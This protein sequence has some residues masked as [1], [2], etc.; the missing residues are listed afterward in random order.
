VAI[1]FDTNALS[2]FVD[3]EQKLLHVIRGETDIALPSIVL[4]EYLY[5]IQQSRMR[6]S[7]EGW[8]KS[9][10]RYFDILPVAHEAADRYAEIRLELKAA[11]TPIPSNDLWIAALARQHRTRLVTRD[12]H[13]RAILGVHILTW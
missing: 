9:N 6:A 13:F 10:L 12:R 11:G 1:I 7:Y 8:I 2:A 5:G 4:G 3:G